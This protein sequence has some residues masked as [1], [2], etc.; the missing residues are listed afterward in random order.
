MERRT[1]HEPL[2]RAIYN[3]AVEMAPQIIKALKEQQNDK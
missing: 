3:I 1:D 2:N